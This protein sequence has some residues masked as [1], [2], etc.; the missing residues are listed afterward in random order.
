MKSTILINRVR[1]ALSFFQ[2]I[3]VLSVMVI[4]FSYFYSLSSMYLP[5]KI[6]EVVIPYNLSYDQ[7][8]LLIETGAPLEN[9]K[10]FLYKDG[11]K[12]PLL[13]KDKEQTSRYSINHKIL[14]SP[15]SWQG[16]LSLLFEM[17]YIAMLVYGIYLLKRLLVNSAEKTP[18][19]RQNVK[20]IRM[21]SYLI[22]GS[23]V[24]KWIYHDI[25]QELIKQSIDSSY[26]FTINIGFNSDTF[27]MLTLGFLILIL[28][29][30]FEHG[31][32]LKEEAALTI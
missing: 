30:V 21:L 3:L 17:I 28:A 2:V 26:I 23:V 25:I 15:S 31:V 11:K 6:Q 8:D 16:L 20:T 4:L 13:R 1:T 22:F 19:L 14:L 9:S 5:N 27:S 12:T 32:E 18:F 24:L 29:Y 7:V 10:P